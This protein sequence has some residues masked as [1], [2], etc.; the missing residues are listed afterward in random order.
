MPKSLLMKL[1]AER[2]RALKAYALRNGW[3]WKQKLFA[4]WLTG[5]DIDAPEGAILR[6]I[7]NA[8]GPAFLRRIR[9]SHLD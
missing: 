6:E 9:P 5:H 4:D 1:T 7:R 2:K 8:C 3:F